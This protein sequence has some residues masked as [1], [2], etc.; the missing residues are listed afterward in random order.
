MSPEQVWDIPPAQT[1]VLMAL[2]HVF[3]RDGRATVRSVM[4]ETSLKSASTVHRHLLALRRE[5]LVV[6]HEGLQASLRPTCR[7]IPRG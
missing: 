5:G 2:L 3:Q 6:W 7:V 1:N 4:E